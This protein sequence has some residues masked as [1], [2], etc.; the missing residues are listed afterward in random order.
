[1]GSEILRQEKLH[2]SLDVIS[3][4]SFFAV[5]SEELGGLKGNLLEH[6]SDQRV[7]DVHSL[8]RD[9]NV[10]RNGLEDLVDVERERLVVLSL[11]SLGWSAG[12]SSR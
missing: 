8:L 7:D 11:G 3:R 6:I 9:S 12:V 10:V 4:Q 2:G 1:M 5:V